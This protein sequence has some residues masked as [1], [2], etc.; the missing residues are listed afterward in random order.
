MTLAGDESRAPRDAAE[1]FRKF[2]D[3]L[4]ELGRAVDDF[5]ASLDKVDIS[6]GHLEEHAIALRYGQHISWFGEWLRKPRFVGPDD[7]DGVEAALD[8]GT[9]TEEDV[10]ALRRAD[11]LV[12]GRACHGDHE[13][14]VLAVEVSHTI[15]DDDVRRAAERAVLLQ[16]AGYAAR[17]LAAGQVLA[18]SAR[19]L[20][21]REG[22]AV[23]LR[24][25]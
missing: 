19:D 13:E 23:D 15:G 1:A 25:D 2:S 20:A 16:R 12:L 7:L 8:N 21:E 17:G 14:T 11:F 4:D 24:G 22:V 10:R 3:A 5:A 6:I 9:L 18:A